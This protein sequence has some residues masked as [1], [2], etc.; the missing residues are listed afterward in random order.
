MAVIASRAVKGFAS[1]DKQMSAVAATGDDARQSL[2]GLRKTALQAGADTQFSAEEAAAGITNLIKA[3]RSAKQIMGGDL[4]GVLNLATAGELEVANAAEIAANTMNQFGD[5]AGSVTHVADLLVSGANAASGEVTD[6]ADA[7]NNV[8]GVAHQMGYSLE[9]TIGFLT[10]MAYS[11]RIG[12]EAGTQMKSMLLALQAP[13]SKAK[14][15]MDELN[16][17]LYDS[18]GNTKTLT[19]FVS[20]YRASLEGK[21]QAEKDSYNATIFGSYGIQAANMA[22][23]QAG[24]SLQ[25]WIDKINQQG[26]AQRQAAIL[27]DNLAGDIERLGGSFDTVFIKSGSGANN[28]LRNMAQ[29]AN[30][31]V[32]AVRGAS[33]SAADDSCHPGWRGRSD[34]RWGGWAAETDRRCR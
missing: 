34:R 32:D 11:G 26:A 20:E 23:Q 28:V 18:A 1:F 14:G 16:L 10:Q 4:T 7:L 9:E 6:M 5:A 19:Q 12:A 24:G 25:E 13:S 22:Y 8:G 3:G 33:R 21:T 30:V 17:S 2:D 31:L 29:S 15:M 27:T